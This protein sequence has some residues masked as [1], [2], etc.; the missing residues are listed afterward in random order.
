MPRDV[1]V[2][3]DEPKTCEALKSFFEQKGFHVATA[4]SLQSALE[5]VSHLQAGV[6]V[7]DLKLPDGSG[8]ELLSRLQAKGSG[9][10]VVVVGA[11]E[12]ASTIQEA[13]RRGAP[14]SLTK[15]VNFSQCFYA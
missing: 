4:S 15:P 6:V 2:V 7:L 10:K 1:L 8:L 3:E 12:D 5:S 11:R 9:L 14:T 13:Y